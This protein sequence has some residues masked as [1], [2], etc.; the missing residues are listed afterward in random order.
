MQFIPIVPQAKHC[1]GGMKN[2][3]LQNEQV[4]K[5]VV[6]CLNDQLD[7]EVVCVSSCVCINEC[8]LK[9]MY[10]ATVSSVRVTYS[11]SQCMF[12]E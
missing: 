6:Q 5:A 12:D 4:P 2:S 9:C 7:T 8:M 3:L 1:A 10:I 11:S